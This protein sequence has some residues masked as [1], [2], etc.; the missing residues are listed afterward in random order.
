M[1]SMIIFKFITEMSVFILVVINLWITAENV[2]CLL[3]SLLMV[4]QYAAIW[5]SIQDL[6]LTK[7]HIVQVVS[8][9]DRILKVQGLNPTKP[10]ASP[11]LC[12]LMLALQ[13]GSLVWSVDYLMHGLPDE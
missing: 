11:Q 1:S 10:F 4:V 5:I 9:L 8:T 3:G 6:V 7:Q 12:L 2:V 13:L